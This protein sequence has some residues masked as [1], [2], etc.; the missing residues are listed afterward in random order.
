MKLFENIIYFAE[1]N[2][3]LFQMSIFAVI[4]FIWFLY[5]QYI[6][7]FQ[8]MEESFLSQAYHHS[9]NEVERKCIRKKQ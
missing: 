9:N 6:I 7:S 8:T 4:L 5:K 3:V 2:R 1:T